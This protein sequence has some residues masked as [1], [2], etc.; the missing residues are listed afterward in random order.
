MGK[1]LLLHVVMCMMVGVA[2]ECVSWA[3][4]AAASTSQTVVLLGERPRTQRAGKEALVADID[5]IASSTFVGKRIVNMTREKEAV[6]ETLARAEAIVRSKPAVVI[7]FTGSA[8]EAAGGDDENLRKDLVALVRTFA[9]EGSEVF[10]IP[11]STSVGADI[12]ANLRLA[13]E[14]AAVHY[15][16]PGTDIG[17]NAYSQALR[18]VAKALSPQQSK[19]QE[20]AKPAIV[21]PTP[22]EVAGETSGTE[23]VVAVKPAATPATIYM[24]PPPALKHFDPRETPTARKRLGKLKKPAVEE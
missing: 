14:D 3:A 7:I 15:L 8:D 5:T 19:S 23:Q 22:R 12:C 21:V 17:G 13:A 4:E 6:R 11:S 18:D 10:L 9:K 16:E 24:V 1:R 2:L 20:S